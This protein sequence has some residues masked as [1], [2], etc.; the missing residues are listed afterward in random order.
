MLFLSGQRDK[1]ANLELLQPVVD[2]LKNATLHVVDT[3][4]HGF[5]ILKRRNTD[6]PVMEEV[7]RVAYGWMSR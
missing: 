4:D 5:K 1:M 7:A 3:A 2:N 6:E